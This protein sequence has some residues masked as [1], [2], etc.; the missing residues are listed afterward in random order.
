MLDLIGDLAD[1]LEPV[2]PIPRLRTVVGG[3]LLLWAAVAG[4][5]IAM[6]G[7]RPDFLEML[8]HVRGTALIFTGLGVAGLGGLLASLALG[9]PGREGAVRSGFVVAGIGMALAAGVGTLLFLQNPVFD[10]PVPLRADLDCL[11]VS[12]SVALLPALGISVF[13]ARTVPHRPLVLVLAAA[14]AMAAMGGATAQATCPADDP[15]HLMLGHV[16][17]PAVGAL[18]LT[19]PLLFALRRA[20]RP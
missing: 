4:L 9:V 10:S 18:V 13:G 17:A 11:I 3:L 15:R 7:L 19:F 20:R 2:T 8:L 1:D 12:L 16:L 6:R 5:G 14:A